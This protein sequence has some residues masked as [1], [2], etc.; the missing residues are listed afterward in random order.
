[1]ARKA[2]GD[3][4][5]GLSD[6]DAIERPCLWSALVL[7][8][9]FLNAG[10]RSRSHAC[11]SSPHS[12]HH[13]GWHHG[14]TLGGLE[15]PVRADRLTKAIIIGWVANA[16]VALPL[17]FAGAGAYSFASG[18]LAGSVVTGVL[19]FKMADLPIELGL[20]KRIAKRLFSFGL[21]LAVSL[22]IEAVLFNAD[23]VIV[24]N[25]LGVVALG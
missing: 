2:G 8:T 7:R 17:A 13:R 15:S 4:A 5:D 16:S 23:Y 3:G 19:V 12:G 24:G 25:V 9:P 21:P 1:V 6:R 10:G 20:D 22:G 14:G 18:Q 11:S